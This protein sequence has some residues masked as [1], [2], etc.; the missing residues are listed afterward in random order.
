MLSAFWVEAAAADTHDAR[1]LGLVEALGGSQQPR[2]MLM[3][4]DLVGTLAGNSRV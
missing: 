2:L 4:L 1:P 3:M